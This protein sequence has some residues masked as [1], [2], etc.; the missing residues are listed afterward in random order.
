MRVLLIYPLFPKTFWSYE[1]LL[2]LVNRKVLLP[3]LGLVTVAA[4]LP[5]DWEFKLVDRNVRAVTEAEWDWAELVIFSAM[6]VQKEDMLNQIREAKLRGKR[7]ACGGPYPTAIPQESKAAG[8]DYLILDEGEITLPMFVDAVQQGKRQG[9]FRSEG[10]K[11]D[12]TATPIP[13]FDLLE[14][15]AYDSMSIQFSRGCPF[16]CEFCDIIVLYGRKPRTKTPAQLI[17][18]LECLYELGW[19]RSIFMVDDNFIG[20][21][22]NVKLLLRQLQPWVAER[23]YPF[24]FT[25]EA[26]V[27][28][29]NDQELMDLMTACRFVA[30]FLGIE[31]P[32]ATS[33]ATTH[34]YQ[35]TRDPLSESVNKIVRSG[36]R[37][38]AGFIIGFDGEQTGAGDR[39]VQF[40]EQTAI[41]TALFSMLQALPDTALW[42]R[43]KKEGRLW[44]ASAN[45][46]QTTLMNFIPT[47]PVEEIAREYIQAFW[48]LYDP[49]RFLDRT[50]RHYLTLNQA[51]CHRTPRKK[52]NVTVS[53]PKQ[54]FDWSAVRAL[55]LIIWRQ[56]VVRKTRFSF[57][58]YLLSMTW[59]YP[60]RV[61]SYL[62]VC[63]QI[64][65]FVE[66][67]Q[68]I[69]DQIEAQLAQF[70]LEETKLKA[71]AAA[72]AASEAIREE[73]LA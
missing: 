43:L 32:D 44:E 46:N 37:V 72:T 51:E 31:T 5:Q 20:N 55:F 41:P 11:P 40:V 50:Y 33:L 47:R 29:A 38:M 2:E 8:V 34:K 49:Q 64:E 52:K 28:L 42:H 12:V 36:L 56:G 19:R 35:N 17:A 24:A 61:V 59:R 15:D 30:V 4:I 45:I 66:Y 1:K 3:P 57:W 54:P 9:V 18:E 67:R 10:I 7:V 48:T 16:Q 23:G 13:R 25:T 6:I 65:H 26:S 69:K 58:R 27:D 22:R 63:A 21:K 68:I 71:Q 62:S 73:I 60:H 39:I 14:F 70:L 53:R